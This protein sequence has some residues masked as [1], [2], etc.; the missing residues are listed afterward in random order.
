MHFR[1]ILA[2]T[3]LSASSSLSAYAETFV[4]VHGAFQTSESWT[5]VAEALRSKGHKVVPVN[6]PGRNAQGAAAKAISISQYVDVVSVAI[7]SQTERVTLVGHSFGGI[8]ISL[9]GAAIPA[10]V[11]KLVYI[12]AYVPVSGESMQSL[13]AGDKTNGFTQK[14]F[15]VSPDY[16]FATILEEDRARLFVNDGGTELQKNAA[17]SMV[18]EPLGPMGTLIEIAPEKLGALEKVYI[19]TTMDKTVSPPTQLMM[20]RRAGIKNIVDIETGHSPQLTKPSALAALI[21]EVSK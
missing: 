18:R 20:I 10:Q 11:K 19:R 9:V 8:T 3:V 5:Q 15:V 4:I 1:K 6:L 21:I 16:T 12:A 7:K 14:S 13:A 17:L 2:I